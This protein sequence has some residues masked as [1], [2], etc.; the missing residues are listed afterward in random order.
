MP[1]VFDLAEQLSDAQLAGFMAELYEEQEEYEEEYLS[2]TDEE[3]HG[4][5]FKNFS[6]NLSDIM[7]RLQPSQ[8][9]RLRDAAANLQRFDSLWLE[10]R[11]WWLEQTETLLQRQPGWQEQALDLIARRDELEYPEYQ[12]VNQHNQDVIQA[13]VADVLNARTEKQDA[14]LHR[15]IEDIRRDLQKLIDQRK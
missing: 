15:E 12:A 5:S 13:A 1:M 9:E 7:G 2:R 3:V 14:R 4:R 8:K 10:Q 11:R 6:E